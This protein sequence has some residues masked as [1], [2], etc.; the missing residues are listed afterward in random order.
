MENQSSTTP[1]FERDPETTERLRARDEHLAPYLDALMK[2]QSN[3]SR[4]HVFVFFS[5]EDDDGHVLELPNGACV[6]DALRES[7]RAFG[8]TS[9][10]MMEQNIIRNG[11]VTSVTQQL[12]NGD[13]ITIPNVSNTSIS[14]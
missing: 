12:R 1:L 2:D 9:S 3:L 4:E 7:E 5:T 6:L 14:K 10:R 13:I 11:S 8:F